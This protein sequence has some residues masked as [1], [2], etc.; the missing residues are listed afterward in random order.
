[1]SIIFIGI[2]VLYT[3]L[4]GLFILGYFRLN[5]FNSENLDNL[6]RFSV[7]IPFRNEERNLPALLD[8]LSELE[9]SP[10]H[11]E[12]LF[13]DDASDDNSVK[14]LNE[15]STSNSHLDI[16]IIRNTIKTKS[17]K[18][19][20]I[21]TAIQASKYEWILSTDADCRINPNWFNSYNAFIQSENAEFVAGPVAYL[22]IT[23]WLDHFQNFD[24]MSLQLGTMGGFGLGK[25]FMCNGANLAYKKSLF[26]ELNGF[27][28][29]DHIGSGDD[30]FLMHKALAKSTIVRYLKSSDAIIWTKPQASFSELFQQRKRWA[31]KTRSYSNLFSKFVAII[32]LFMNLGILAIF[33]TFSLSKISLN[34]LLIYVVLKFIVDLIAIRLA[35]KFFNRPMCTRY[36]IL[37][38]I[39]YPFFVFMVSFG[40]LVKGYHWKGRSYDQ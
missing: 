27:E 30:I 8:S 11:F 28:N 21:T 6:I 25:P 15:F 22:G 2:A 16:S 31:A 33:T 19:K 10:T 32:V 35:S 14:L 40:S 17:P 3:T 1:M 18:K 36:F 26:L 7:V 12:L 37:S 20:A 34:L 4:I 23:N 39:F 9:Y 13:V 5:L 38:F 29:N 24:M